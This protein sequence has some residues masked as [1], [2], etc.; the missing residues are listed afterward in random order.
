MS[1]IAY[2]LADLDQQIADAQ[3]R[4]TAAR[5]A[6][7]RTPSAERIAAVHAA[8]ADRDQLLEQRHTLQHQ[9]SGR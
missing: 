8:V 6:C 3:T 9:P 5:A 7:R 1:A 4:L 2:R